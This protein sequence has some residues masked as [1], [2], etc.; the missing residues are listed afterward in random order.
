[1]VPSPRAR[2]A[3]ALSQ[4]LELDHVAHRRLEIRA[5]LA[6]VDRDVDAWW[7]CPGT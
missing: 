1:M 6:K 4:A 5:R 7:S 2:T 3:T